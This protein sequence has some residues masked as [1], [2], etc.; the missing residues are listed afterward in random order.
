MKST[1]VP[2]SL[3][4]KLHVLFMPVVLQSPISHAYI[5]NPLHNF[6]LLTYRLMHVEMLCVAYKRRLVTDA[7]A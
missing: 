1:K 7:K 4:H 3:H 5:E 2:V 6:F